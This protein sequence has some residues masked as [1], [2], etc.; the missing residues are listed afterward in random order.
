MLGSTS[1]LAFNGGAAA[2]ALGLAIWQWRRQDGRQL[3]PKQRLR[4]LLNERGQ[5]AARLEHS[6]DANT[7]NTSLLRYLALHQHVQ[8]AGETILSDNDAAL[9]TIASL[10]ETSSERIALEDFMRWSTARQ[11]SGASHSQGDSEIETERRHHWIQAAKALENMS[12][13]T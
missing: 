6:Q 12:I 11:W 4:Q 9:R 10:P 13:A 3:S 7:L 8:G 1:L 5:I 2:L